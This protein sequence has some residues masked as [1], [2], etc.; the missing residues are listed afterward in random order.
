MH[1]AATDLRSSNVFGAFTASSSLMGIGH[2]LS[3]AW[4]SLM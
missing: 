1:F 2:S 4:A 3:A